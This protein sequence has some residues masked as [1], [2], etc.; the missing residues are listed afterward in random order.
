MNLTAIITVVTM[1]ILPFILYEAVLFFNLEIYGLKTTII[2]AAMPLGVT[3]YVLSVQYKLKTT[4][5][6]RTTVL[7]TLL[8]V[9]IIPLWM[10]WLG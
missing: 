8:S 4:L 1:L 10:V 9:I 5:V 6:V 3:P 2:D 7:G